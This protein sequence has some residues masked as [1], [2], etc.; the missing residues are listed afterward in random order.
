MQH[1]VR[2][3]LGAWAP[4]GL[5]EEPRARPKGRDR[6][7]CYP[8]KRCFLAPQPQ[9]SKES[10]KA[11]TRNISKS[12]E[13]LDAQVNS[14]TGFT[15]ENA[16]GSEGTARG[17]ET[18]GA[19]PPRRRLSTQ[20]MYEL[21]TK[22]RCSCEGW[23]GG[24]RGAGWGGGSGPAGPHLPPALPA[25]V[26]DRGILSCRRWFKRKHEQ[27][28]QRVW[29]PLLK[30]LLCLPMTFKFFCGIAKG[31]R[32]MGGGDTGP[33]SAVLGAVRSSGWGRKATRRAGLGG[34]RAQPLLRLYPQLTFTAG[35]VLSLHLRDGPN[36]STYPIR[37]F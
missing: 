12:F 7:L 2:V 6:L 31:R 29:V 27:C 28:L 33:R 30:H 1:G 35:L 9:G 10:L 24:G 16:T 37:G 19:R 36:N 11:K 15:L 4:P 21:K 13:D 17:A 22:L 25:D 8:P 14:D 3:C 5:R 32:A 18:H 26:V 20:K 34:T 23:G